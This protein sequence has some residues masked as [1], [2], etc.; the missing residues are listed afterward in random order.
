[1][2][3][4][5]PC[6]AT[7]TLAFFQT[8]CLATRQPR[9]ALI[10]VLVFLVGGLLGAIALNALLQYG[11]VTRQVTESGFLVEGPARAWAPQWALAIVFLAVVWSGGL[12]CL[13]WS[14]RWPRLDQR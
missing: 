4:L 10:V 8:Y 13:E 14:R 9:R 2:G 5:I 1:V 12:A 7:L 11:R 6:L 3:L